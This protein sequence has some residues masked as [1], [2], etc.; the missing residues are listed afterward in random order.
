VCDKREPANNSLQL[1]PHFI[2]GWLVLYVIEGYSMNLREREIAV[3]RAK[4]KRVLAHNNIIADNYKANSTGTI[5]VVVGGFK[6]YSHKVHNALLLQH[7][8]NL[9]KSCCQFLSLIGFLIN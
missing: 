8:G 3:R 1:G 9:K 6:I 4:Q 7:F 5:R 2:E